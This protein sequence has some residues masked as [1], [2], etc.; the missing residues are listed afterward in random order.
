MG[1]LDYAI[2][3]EVDH[4]DNDPNDTGFIQATVTIGGRDAVKEYTA[5]KIFPLASSFSFKSVPLGTCDRTTSGRGSSL[6]S[7]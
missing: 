6:G 3:P 1:E 2:E 5:C 4:R 7:T